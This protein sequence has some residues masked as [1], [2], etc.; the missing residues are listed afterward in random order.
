MKKRILSILLTIVMVMGLVPTY[1]LADECA[2]ENLEWDGKDGKKDYASHL[3]SCQSCGMEIMWEPHSDGGGDSKCD[4]CSI[5]LDD[6]NYCVHDGNGAWDGEMLDDID[7][8]M[9]CTI[10][11]GYWEDHYDGDDDDSKCDVCLILL[12]E[13]NQ[14]AHASGTAW[15]GNTTDYINHWMT[16]TICGGYWEDH[17]DNNSDSKCDVC[18]ISLD[19]NNCCA[20]TDA[21]KDSNC[22][23][24]GM[25]VHGETAWEGERWDAIDHWI[26]CS[27]CGGYYEAHYD[28]DSDSKCD[29]CGYVMSS[30]EDSVTGYPMWIGGQQFTAEKLEITGGSG[31]AAFTP[32][33]DGSPA[34]LTL[35]NYTYTGAGYNYVLGEY[36]AICYTGSEPLTLVLLGESVVTHQVTSH[37]TYSYGLFSTSTTTVSEGSTGSLTVTGGEITADNG[38]GS[39]GVYIQNGNLEIQ[40]GSLTVT[41]GEITADNGRGSFG[42]YIQNGNLEIQGGSL[43]AIGGTVSAENGESIGAN[44]SYYISVSAGSLTAIGS[45]AAESYGIDCMNFAN[46]TGGTAEAEG[47]TL[48]FSAAPYTEGYTGAAYY[49]GESKDAADAAGAKYRDELET[50]YHNHKYVRIEHGHIFTSQ[51][52]D[53]GHWQECSDENCPDPDKGKTVSSPHSFDDDSDIICDVCNYSR[54]EHDYEITQNITCHDKVCSLCGNLVEEDHSDSEDEDVFCD[55]CGTCMEH[56]E[57]SYGWDG[58]TWIFDSHRMVC[59][60]CGVYY[61]MK[62]HSDGEDEDFLC[63]VCGFRMDCLHENVN[64]EF[65]ENAHWEDC[66]ICSQAIISGQSHR[67]NSQRYHT[68]SDKHYLMCDAC[69]YH[70]EDG[71]E[72]IDEDAD[73]YCDICSYG[74]HEHTF[75]EGFWYQESGVHYPQ[76]DAC[77][78]YDETQGAE[79]TDEDNNHGCDV[80]GIALVD[81]CTDKDNDHVCDVCIYRM[82]TL[83]T[84]TDDNHICDAEACQRYMNELCNDGDNGDWICNICGNNLC[85][86]SF[87]GDPVPESDRIHS[88]ECEYCGYATEECYP[89]DYYD[90]DENVHTEVC[91]CG[92]ELDTSEHTFVLSSYGMSIHII[93]CEQCFFD[94]WEGHTT[95]DGICTVCE[96]QVTAYED[97]YVGGIGLKDGEYLDNSGNVSA[98]QP[99]GGYAYYTDGVLELNGYSYEGAGSQWMKYTDGSVDT[100]CIYAAVENLIVM[101]KGENSLTNTET[102]MTVSGNGIVAV[103]NLTIRGDGSLTI[104]V[105][106]NGILSMSGDILKEGGTTTIAVEEWE[107][108]AAE[109]GNISIT[110]G[111]LNITATEDEGIDLNGNGVFT[112]S[113]GILNI[114]AGN[115]GIDCESNINISGG[116]IT[117]TAGTSGLESEGDTTITGGTICIQSVTDDYVDDAAPALLA[118][119]GG[120]LILENMR[121]SVPSFGKVA[122]VTDESLGDYYTIVD[123]DNKAAT[124]V[125]LVP[126]EHDFTDGVCGCGL[127]DAALMGSNLVLEGRIGMNFYFRMHEALA[128]NKDTILRFTFANGT[129]MDAAVTD[130]RIDIT[131]LPGT[132]LYKFSCDVAAKEMADTVKVQIILDNNASMIYNHSVVRYARMLLNGSNTA[133]TDDCKALVKSMLNYGTYAQTHFGYN[134]ENLSNAS[135]TADEIAAVTA[136]EDTVFDTY[137]ATGRNN[138]SVGSF[139]G[140]SLVLESETTLNVYFSPADGVSL[141]NLT[142]TVDGKSVPA[143]STEISETAYYM[144]S[145]T[146]IAAQ[147]LD[148]AFEVTVSNGTESSSYQVSAFSYCHDV[149]LQNTGTT[150]TNEL[151]N[152]LKAL[153]LYNQTANKYFDN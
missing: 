81:F 142:F 35:N 45:E 43:T 6:I 140:S 41:G 125:E 26:T 58:K 80:C 117:I 129:T 20:H 42:V 21:D 40:G 17:C 56:T 127:L 137:A 123:A 79:C 77:S 28:N 128:K 57:D 67:Y 119:D 51:Y 18:F 7:H 95:R 44:A 108:I 92:N 134:T 60:V 65:D 5:S 49:Y 1:V 131:S 68:E 33:E 73:E 138:T 83:C 64:M 106:G 39:F 152:A 107:G 23:V 151:K 88:G 109:C 126:H 98:T 37:A 25:C 110:G 12:D 11:G 15:D 144:I 63:D 59:R 86:H 54:C 132:T 32:A 145:I 87:I 136:V 120:R 85:N 91:I 101:L 48:A 146:N 105:Y 90:V 55:V 82:D 114:A 93:Y 38:R 34:T 76:C 4:V 100:A 24:C 139:A 121:I 2:H 102:N 124:M 66:T 52:N 94:K 78:Y 112:M 29:V 22:D 130:A 13:N 150:Y 74:I 3:M 71:E 122:V 113:G 104:D 30:T 50:D 27:N 103:K 69:E 111:T 148:K 118:E 61:G 143:V 19:E 70:K 135:L 47:T 84:D 10:C 133:Y 153:Y 16:C 14:C 8:W 116:T 99:A 46:I 149:M 147:D 72:H 9:T 62:D 75:E 141:E 31:T 89:W 115:D 96:M 53:S 36:N 97:V